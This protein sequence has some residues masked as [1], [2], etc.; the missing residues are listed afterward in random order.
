MVIPT[1]KY[2]SNPVRPEMTAKHAA[3]DINS[4]IFS[5]FSLIGERAVG[6]TR[7]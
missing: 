2:F 1:F 4:L 3:Q 6:K 5:A 7:H